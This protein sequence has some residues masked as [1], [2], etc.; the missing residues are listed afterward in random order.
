MEDIT[1][2]DLKIILM[3]AHHMAKGDSELFFP[4]K[5]LLGRFY[6]KLRLSAMEKKEVT[7][8][9]ISLSESL[10]NLSGENAQQKLV[11]FLCA[12][13][14]VDGK[15]NEGELNFIEKVVSQIGGKMQ[16][17]PVEDW[18]EYENKATA[19][20]EDIDVPPKIVVAEDDENIGRLVQYKLEGSGFNV[21]WRTDGAKALKIIEEEIPDLVV[22]DIDMPEMTGFEVLAAMKEKPETSSI[23]VIMLTAQKTKADV[24]KAIELGVDDYVVKPFRPAELLERIKTHLPKP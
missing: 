4:E 8:R 17:L 16:L 11:E 6:G 3:F 5:K 21:L 15:M 14:L 2:N 12:V 9:E 23:P 13:A 20:V 19:F 18:G 10:K 24:G 22:L 7:G 1:R